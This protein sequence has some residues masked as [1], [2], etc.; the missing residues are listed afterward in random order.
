MNQKKVKRLR[1]IFRNTY[2]FSAEDQEPLY[3]IRQEVVESSQWRQ[4]KKE[5]GHLNI[6]QNTTRA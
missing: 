2:G 3:N 5:N 1:A 4:F 6:R